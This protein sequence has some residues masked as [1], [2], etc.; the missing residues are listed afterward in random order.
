MG[1]AVPLGPVGPGELRVVLIGHGTYDRNDGT[2]EV[3]AHVTIRF[4]GP[5][6]GNAIGGNNDEVCD[7]AHDLRTGAR[8]NEYRLWPMVGERHR[9]QFGDGCPYHHAHHPEHQRKFAAGRRVIMFS[10][11]SGDGPRLSSIV[12]RV[13]ALAPPGIPITFLWLACREHADKYAAQS[14]M[15]FDPGAEPITLD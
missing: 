12:N 1:A 6:G 9:F 7:P 15:I 8:C 13:Q 3:P 5:D 4:K 2:F 10:A 11:R 14:K